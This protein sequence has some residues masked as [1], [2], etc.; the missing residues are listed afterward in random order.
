MQD[1]DEKY[2]DNK[3][4]RNGDIL[5]VISYNTWDSVCNM[6]FSL[7]EGSKKSYLQW[8]PFSKL[9]NS[10]KEFIRSK[11]FYEKYISTAAFIFFPLAMYQSENFLQK[12]DGSF[13]E[14]SLVSP[15]LYLILQAIG[16]EIYER[17]STSRPYNVLAYYAGN[18]KF[19]RPKYKQDYDNFFKELN[20]C[21]DEYQYFIKTD[22]TN[23]FA[24]INIDKL[25]VQIDAVCNSKKLVFTQIQL[26]LF[27]ELL[28]YCGN[29]RFPLIENSVASSFLATIVYL[30]EID[31]KLYNYI[32][33]NV[34]AFSDFRIIRYVDDMY[35]LISSNKPIEF[36]HDAYNEIR[37]EYSSI[38]KEYGLALNTKKCC[39][40]ET[41]E[42]NHELKKSL[43]DEYF[44]GKKHDIEEMF[45][46]SLYNFLKELSEELLYDSI[47]V[48]KYNQLID[49][50]FS[51]ED[52]EFTAGEVFNYFIYE[53]DSELQTNSVITEIVRLV[54]QSISFISLDPKRLTIM[55]M[56]TK[57]DRAIKGFLNQLF[58][59]NKAG[60]WNSYDTTIAISY[61]MQR[62]F[63]HIDLLKILS[64]NHH[65]LYK[66]YFYNCKSSFLE[67][68]A[69]EVTN[70]LCDTINMDEKARY[71]Y[72]M[73]LCEIKRKN[74]M[75]AFAYFKNCFDRVTADLDFVYNY[76]PRKR[77][78]NY[79]GFYK[80]GT[81]ISFY[82]GFDNSGSIIQTAHKLRNANPLAHSSSDLLDD[83]NSTDN[84]KQN[85]KDLTSLICKYIEMKMK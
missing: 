24:N 64:Q 22:I 41:K 37:N 52:I 13:R 23:F 62:E 6:Y 2:I 78:P 51:A 32:T 40:K 44:S 54:E 76:D 14:S 56:K 50:H 21:I 63:K 48:E 39:F 17:Y 79:K 5:F 72:F 55:I 74:Y 59:R 53:N 82:S 10:D 31:N 61:L 4:Q 15:V 3:Y 70:K 35:I 26:Q 8:F 27:K 57:S 36:L 60:K 11:E 73:Y 84:L 45:N 12:A 16:K 66:Y 34:S 58:K 30:D 83:K 7:K 67:C 20:S 81:F 28:K 29:G 43:Y 9:T 80:E 18:Y 69:S 38:L 77:K 1:K 46:G 75:V 68:F 71:L 47:D 19:M 49:K 85:I 33:K 25:I 42:I 65:D